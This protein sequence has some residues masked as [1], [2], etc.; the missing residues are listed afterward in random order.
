M[1]ACSDYNAGYVSVSVSCGD[2]SI[3]IQ[4]FPAE[5][6]FPW[7]KGVLGASD[8]KHGMSWDKNAGISVVTAGDILFL[9]KVGETRHVE[10]P[11]SWPRVKGHTEPVSC[12][13]SSLPL[14]HLFLPHV[15]T[16]WK[17]V[18]L[19]CSNEHWCPFPE[20]GSLLIYLDFFFQWHYETEAL[21]PGSMG[22]E[23]AVQGG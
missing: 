7:V 2:D 12:C 6:T 3:G 9:R 8:W 11:A 17:P 23:T 5:P 1:T 13:Q 4:M 21:G 18:H 19:L 14:K 10:G 20:S 16:G 15:V 22:Q